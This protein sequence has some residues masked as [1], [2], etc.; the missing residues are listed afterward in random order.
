MKKKMK[1]EPEPRLELLAPAQNKEC[2]IAAIKYGAD[3]VYM[4]AQAYGA[5]SKAG[6]SLEDIKEVVNYAHKFYAKVYVTVNTILDDNEILEARKL[7]WKLYEI[8]VDAVIIQ[9]FGLLELAKD[10]KL[11]PIKLFASTQCDNRT[12]EKIKFFENTGVSRVILARELS[13]EDIKN[14]CKNTAIEIETF[15]HGS[16]CVSYSGQCYL[17]YICGGR[18]AN[19]GE[20]AQVCRK[21]YTLI[22]DSGKILLKD[23]HLLNLKDFNAS[24]YIDELAG[25]GVTS[26]KIEGRM[27]DINY[28]KNVVGYYRRL[29]DKYPKTSSGKVF[30]DFE[31]NPEKSFNRGF[32]SYFLDGCK[33]DIH[34][35]DTPKSTGEKLGKITEVG[36]N[37]FSIDTKSKIAPQD[38][39][40]FIVN[41]ELTGCLV[42]SV[43]GKKIYPNKMPLSLVQNQNQ[44]GNLVYRNVDAEFEKTLNNSKTVR[45]IGVTF[46][47][48]ENA[49]V[50]KDEDGNVASIPFEAEEIAQNQEKMKECFVSQLQKTGESDF[51]VEDIEI[52]ARVFHF[53][54]VSKIN[55]LRREIFVLLTEERIKSYTRDVQKQ[56]RAAVFP[57]EKQNIKGDYKL[58]IHNRFA[59]KFMQECGCHIQEFSLESTKRVNKRCDG[60]VKQDSLET[61][62]QNKE[63]MRCKYC[64]KQ[65]IN[66]CR[67]KEKLYLTDDKKRKF[68]LE[69]DCKKCEMVLSKEKT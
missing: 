25:A 69:F 18:S 29:L 23:K 14:I 31:P 57:Q 52:K 13:L 60:G 43:E 17:S 49:L 11:P 66:R 26:F 41:G 68:K 10:S 47:V 51:Y 39:L 38:G 54:P 42:N 61:T 58:N 56:I 7:I 1:P 15:I 4:G 16:L 59:E 64:I 34:N 35:F 44:V 67:S 28:I 45:K 37:Y 63:L 36:K 33:E 19:R 62:S 50:V 53:L 22:D 3:A 55:E 20:C 65:A 8:G 6:N 24:K 21:K 48:Y 32:C 46:E 27:K 12:L 9:D 5:R 30:F 2:A 40:C